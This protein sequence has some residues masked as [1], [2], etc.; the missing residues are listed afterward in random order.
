MDNLAIAPD[1]DPTEFAPLAL[2]EQGDVDMWVRRRGAILIEKSKETAKDCEAGKLASA[3]TVGASV[4]M[5]SNPL[6]WLPLT[7]G[8][9][10]YVY[11]VFQEFQDTGSIRLIPMYRGK[12]GDILKVM[13]GGIAEQRHPLLDQIEYLSEAEKDEVL[14]INYRFGEIAGVLN[15]AP[16][17]VRFDLYRHLCGQFHARRDLMSG[18]EV[19]HY[20]NAATSEARRVI[21]PQP[22]PT[23]EQGET[24]AITPKS[25]EVEQV[26][27][28]QPTPPVGDAPK[29]N[30]QSPVGIPQ[31][32]SMIQPASSGALTPPKTTLPA[33]NRDRIINES[34]GL[35]VLGDMGAAK[36]CVVQYIANGFDGYGIIVFDPHGMTDWG[37][38]YVIT[39]MAAIYEQM[40]IL[41]DL[42]ESGDTTSLLIICDE[43]LEIRGDRRN[44]KGS[45]Y[46]GLADDFIRLFSTK[47]RKF[48]K[49][50]AF[51]LHSPNVE[52][53]GVDSFLRE[54]YLKIYLGRL[55]KK[56]FPQVQD[57]AYPCVLEDEQQEHPTHGH[58]TEFKPKG[59]APRN[60][61]PLQSAPITIPLA[62]MDGGE[63][64]VCDRG[65]A[66]G[67]L[68]LDVANIRNQLEMLYRDTSIDTGNDTDTGSKN[69]DTN[70]DTS[71]T[72]IDTGNSDT[73]DTADT[74]GVS[75]DTSDTKPVAGKL[76]E[77]ELVSLIDSMIKAGLS[78]T[79]IICSLWSVEKNKAGWKAAYIRFKE[80]MG[81]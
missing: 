53:A 21:P 31:S 71:D 40:K 69:S 19:K 54:N 49:L 74:T 42:L 55:A 4:V 67:Q 3:L 6:A 1:F 62:Y 22:Q 20:I 80:L 73:A 56:E 36:T 81:D 43:W 14:L 37:N 41:L 59:K 58:H 50:A 51:V 79:Q 7:I 75:D 64:K 11:T 65:W 27:T 52:A 66:D 60:L 28:E 68:R 34:K 48:N 18:D 44:K 76:P 23:I 8:A 9:I 29:A 26:K 17:K 15:S 24:R 32:T 35:M 25:V 39:K 10:G 77:I 38:A 72:S 5:S 46:A 45:E 12:L 63:V 30:T 57:C 78:Q 2:L 47:P 13:E 70:P 16:P 33:F 61:E